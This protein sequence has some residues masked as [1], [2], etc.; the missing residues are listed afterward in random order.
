MIMGERGTAVGDVNCEMPCVTKQIYK[1]CEVSGSG[2]DK[3]A[4]PCREDAAEGKEAGT[5]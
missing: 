3:D 2:K 5:P 1:R 4:A